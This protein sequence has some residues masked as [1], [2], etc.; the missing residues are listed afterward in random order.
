MRVFRLSNTSP[1]RGRTVL[2]ETVGR[3]VATAG[4]GGNFFS[5]G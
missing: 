2:R 3:V 4:P 1:R 5:A